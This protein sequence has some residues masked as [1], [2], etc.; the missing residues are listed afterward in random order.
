MERKHK[1]IKVHMQNNFRS[2]EHTTVCG[3]LNATIH[4]IINGHTQFKTDYL[5]DPVDGRSSR[6]VLQCGTIHRGDMVLFTLDDG[7]RALG[8]VKGILQ[9]FGSPLFVHVMALEPCSRNGRRLWDTSRP[10]DPKS[11]GALSLPLIRFK[12]PKKLTT[13]LIGT[14]FGR[15]L[16][17]SFAA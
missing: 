16:I 10:Q 12:V 2:V 8:E 4:S 15:T 1:D 7:Q 3:H 17:S 14:K 5:L 9:A 11:S 13:L 6:A